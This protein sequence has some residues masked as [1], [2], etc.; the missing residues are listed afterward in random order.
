MIRKLGPLG[1]IDMKILVPIKRVPHAATSIRVLSD[2]TGIATDNIKWVINPFDEIALEEALRI[3]EKQGSGEVVLLC[4]GQQAW[5]EQL[6]TG[7]AMGADRAILVRADIP[8]D[9]SVIARII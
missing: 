8:L 1:V 4:V 2:G 9:T 3:K 6:R 7:L 5:Q